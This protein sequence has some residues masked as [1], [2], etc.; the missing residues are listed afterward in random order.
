GRLD[1]QHARGR[2]GTGG[3]AEERGDVEH[4]DGAAEV[5]VGP[6]QPRRSAGDAGERGRGEVAPHGAT[7]HAQGTPPHLETH[8][9]HDG[10]RGVGCRVRAMFTSRIARSFASVTVNTK[11]P[12]V[13]RSP[14]AGTCPSLVSRNPASVS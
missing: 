5:V 8:L 7:I 3:H 1:E 14:T 6:E 11:S 2:A 12:H 10:A 9:R 13:S 4:G